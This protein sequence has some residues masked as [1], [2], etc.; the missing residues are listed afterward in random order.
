MKAFKV[1]DEKKSYD[2][3]VKNARRLYLDD[4]FT[5]RCGQDLDCFTRCCAD[6]AIVLTPYDVLRMKRALKMGSSEFLEKYTILP[7]TKDQKVPVVLLNM[8]AEGKRCPF[9]SGKGCEI[10]A[11]RPWACRMYPLGVAEPKNPNPDDKRFYFLLKEDICHGH[12]KGRSMK[13]RE[14]IENQGIEEYDMMGASFKD[15][16]LHDF[17][18]KGEA[19]APRKMEM[20][21]MA[22]FDLDRFRRFVFESTFL[23]KFIVDEARAEAMRND[24]EDLLDFAAQW[25][26]FSLFGEKTMKVRPEFL[27]KPSVGGEAATTDAG[28]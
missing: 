14:W 25:L 16:M 24:D 22:L 27:E 11:N 19:L 17:W 26:R 3:I 9:A 21:H 5:F 8:S 15:L 18:E 12:G 4:E 28:G 6:V 20:Y 1:A 23:E 7:F 10:Y 13:V 2:Q